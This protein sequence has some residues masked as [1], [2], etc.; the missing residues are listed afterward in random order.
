[1]PPGTFEAAYTANRS[2]ANEDAVD[3]DPVAGAM[4]NM[5]AKKQYFSGTAT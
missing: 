1:M 5:M 3:A 2:S 4:L